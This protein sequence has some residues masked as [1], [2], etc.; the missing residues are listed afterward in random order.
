LH[1]AQAHHAAS[2]I[3]HQCY[4]RD[5]KPQH[6]LARLVAVFAVRVF[7]QHGHLASGSPILTLFQGRAAELIQGRF[8][9]AYNQ[10]RPG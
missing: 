7:L 9:R 6:E 8:L 10:I 1:H 2:S 5:Q 3:P 4:R